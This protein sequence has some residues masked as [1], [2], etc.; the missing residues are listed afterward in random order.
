MADE[1]EIT[2]EQE[3]VEE[4]PTVVV[5]ETDS[6][7]SNLELGIIVGALVQRVETLEGM[8]MATAEVATDAAETADVALDV[9][10]ESQDVAIDAAI[11]AETAVEIAAITPDPE[12]SPEPVE[13]EAP[14][15]FVHKFFKPFGNK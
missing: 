8:V 12:P 6:N 2:V 9:A 1:I 5:V 3:P 11:D 7:D 14:T 10:I 4:T 13:D 15:S